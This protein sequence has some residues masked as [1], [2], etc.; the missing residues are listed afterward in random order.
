[1]DCVKMQ[2][3]KAQCERAGN[4]FLIY[5][6]TVLVC[7]G[8]GDFRVFAARID[9]RPQIGMMKRFTVEIGQQSSRQND[10]VF[11][12]GFFFWGL[13]ILS[14]LS[15][16][17]FNGEQLSSGTPCTG[18]TVEPVMS[19]FLIIWIDKYYSIFPIIIGV[20]IIHWSH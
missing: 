3:A 12:M 17:F 14:R 7:V 4:V 10:A 20:V 1:M 13:S 2:R 16:L 18:L 6:V 15:R 8:E 19:V 5:R 11:E 9:S